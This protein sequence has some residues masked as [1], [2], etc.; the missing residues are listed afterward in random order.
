MA[1]KSTWKKEKA[2]NHLLQELFSSASKAGDRAIKYPLEHDLYITSVYHSIEHAYPS[3]SDEKKYKFLKETFKDI[4]L[5]EK[6]WSEDLLIDHYNK[7]CHS[8]Y[9]SGCMEYHVI[10]MLSI[11]PEVSISNKKIGSVN[12][13][14]YPKI[15]EKY[16]SSRQNLFSKIKCLGVSEDSDFTCCIAKCHALDESYAVS[17]SLEAIDFIRGAMMLTISNPLSMGSMGEIRSKIQNPFFVGNIHTAHFPDGN[18]VN[19]NLYW[20]E[21]EYRKRK[22]STL[23]LEGFEDFFESVMSLN[24]KN[25]GIFLAISK[26]MK[27]LSLAFDNQSDSLKIIKIWAIL[28]EVFNIKQFEMR[29]I[30]SYFI[31]GSKKNLAGDILSSIRNSRNSIAHDIKSSQISLDH[32]LRFLFEQLKQLIVGLIKNESRFKS[33]SEYKK[34]ALMIEKTTH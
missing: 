5:E 14:F 30:L 26:I 3:I 16:Q 21:Q 1:K 6:E 23:K 17:Q 15:P 33:I 11:C 10:I 4:I 27:G 13:S 34:L 32:Q 29:K 31:D 12:L 9:K 25:K 24:K 7:K 20:Y 19:E 8:L 28:D 2:C 22:L 18:M